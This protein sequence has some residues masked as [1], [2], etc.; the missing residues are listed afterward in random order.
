MALSPDIMSEQM[1]INFRAKMQKIDSRAKPQ[2]FQKDLC[3][4]VSKGL[5]NSIK[6]S[7]AIGLVPSPQAV[8]GP[9]GFI[10]G[11]GLTVDPQL[12]KN[13][14][15]TSLLAYFGGKGVG[16]SA[17]LE[18]LFTSSCNHLLQFTEIISISGFGGQAGGLQNVNSEII[19]NLIIASLPAQSQGQFSSSQYG[20]LF[21]KGLAEGFS[22]GLQTAIPGI[23][24]F[25]SIPPP[26]GLLIAKF[27]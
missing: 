16:L 7:T 9:S 8:P 6:L 10:S 21:I 20:Q 15:E 23:V 1:L 4:A 19:A 24:P 13:I 14:A 18:A 27:N 5:I 22:A 12:C 2:D 11:I 26:P 3:L 25:G 17:M